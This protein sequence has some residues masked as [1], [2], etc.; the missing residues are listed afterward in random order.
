MIDAE[1]L[2]RGLIHNDFHPNN[3][4]VD[5]AVSIFLVD[6]IDASYSFFIAD[7]ATALFH[8]LVNREHGMQRAKLFWNGYQQRVALTEGEI[9]T[10]DQ[11]VRANLMLSIEEDLQSNDQR[12]QLHS[13]TVATSMIAE[14]RLSMLHFLTV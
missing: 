8:L 13:V 12:I 6:F 11:F 7:L 14:G 3:S 4:L 2:Q 9:E 10:L 1:T 5:H